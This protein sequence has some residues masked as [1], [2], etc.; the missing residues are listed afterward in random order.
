MQEIKTEETTDS[1]NFTVNLKLTIMGMKSGSFGQENSKNVSRFVKQ[2]ETLIE[3]V[4]GKQPNYNYCKCKGDEWTTLEIALEPVY[5]EISK[6]GRSKLR[7]NSV[8]VSRFANSCSKYAD[9]LIAKL[10][11]GQQNENADERQK[12]I[13][14]NYLLYGAGKISVNN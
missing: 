13:Q 11:E 12:K 9:A 8:F 7:F 2:C 5:Q 1:I 3:L 4:T 6:H 10:R 14:Q